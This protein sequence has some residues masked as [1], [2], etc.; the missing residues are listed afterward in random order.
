M[1]N[2]ESDAEVAL[3]FKALHQNPVVWQGFKN[4]TSNSPKFVH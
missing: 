1:N 3:Y 2:L 4:L